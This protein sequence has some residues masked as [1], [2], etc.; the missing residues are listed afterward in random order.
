MVPYSYLYVVV[1]VR[2]SAPGAHL[3]IRAP[4]A[5][6]S[7]PRWLL[8]L[9]RIILAILGLHFRFLVVDLSLLCPLPLSPFAYGFRVVYLFEF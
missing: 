1:D 5:C 7:L 4:V 2:Y 9:V 3:A 8:G 6:F